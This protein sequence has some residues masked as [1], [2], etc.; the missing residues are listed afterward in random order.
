MKNQTVCKFTKHKHSKELIAPKIINTMDDF[1]MQTMMI[2]TA[3]TVV[4]KLVKDQT[5]P[6][7]DMDDKSK[8]VESDLKVKRE[9]SVN[10]RIHTFIRKMLDTTKD[11]SYYLLLNLQYALKNPRDEV[12]R[13]NFLNMCVCY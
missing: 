1:S 5:V 9:G 10:S 7:M 2:I 3:W 8:A 11:Q 12:A 4:V 6:T 13:T